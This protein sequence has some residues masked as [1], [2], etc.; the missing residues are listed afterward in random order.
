[1]TIKIGIN[2]LGRIGRSVARALVVEGYDDIQLV[3]ANGSAANEN[4]AHLLQYD[5]VHGRFQNTITFDEHG[6]DMGR[7][8]RLPRGPDCPQSVTSVGI[9]EM[10]LLLALTHRS[11]STASA[12]LEPSITAAR[13]LRTALRSP[14]FW[15][16]V[17]WAVSAS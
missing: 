13:R 16:V 1:M 9:S 8:R 3:A 15:T 4:H 12:A 2:G 14:T 11:C 6:L 10:K 5:S 7:G 17:P